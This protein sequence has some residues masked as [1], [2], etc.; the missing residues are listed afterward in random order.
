MNV[1][2]LLSFHGRIRDEI[3]GT[4]ML[5]RRKSTV[6]L[7]PLVIYLVTGAI[8]QF[9]CGNRVPL[10]PCFRVTFLMKPDS[11]QSLNM[12]AHRRDLGRRNSPA[13]DK[14]TGPAAFAHNNVFHPFAQDSRLSDL[15]HSLSSIFVSQIRTPK[16]SVLLCCRFL[17]C[18]GPKKCFFF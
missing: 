11:H 12:L 3:E 4:E 18:F 2:K 16:L 1:S 10:G 8:D 9:M 17:F 7:G 13:K 15:F 14:Q 6:G 5:G